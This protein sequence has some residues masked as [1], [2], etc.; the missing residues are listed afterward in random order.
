MHCCRYNQGDHVRSAGGPWL[1][2]YLGKYIPFSSASWSGAVTKL[3]WP[4]SVY[5]LAKGPPHWLRRFSNGLYSSHLDFLLAFMESLYSLSLYI[6]FY[7]STRPCKCISYEDRLQSSTSLSVLWQLVYLYYGRGRKLPC[8][9]DLSGLNDL[10]NAAYFITFSVMTCNPVKHEPVS[11]LM[12]FFQ[13]LW[14][15]S[16]LCRFL[17]FI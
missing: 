5:E 4:S 14:L 11:W 6:R 9:P 13:S 8:V 7:T 10:C 12:I 15:S 17:F 16:A 1:S 2:D 3:G